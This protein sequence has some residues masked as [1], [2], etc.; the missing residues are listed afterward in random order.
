MAGVPRA[1]R[2]VVAAPLEEHDD[3]ADAPLDLVRGEGV[4]DL[5]LGAPVQE[6]EH[7]PRRQLP[8]A[9]LPFVKK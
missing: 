1:L 3:L 8:E 9:T 4:R 5:G 2:G 7:P 6:E